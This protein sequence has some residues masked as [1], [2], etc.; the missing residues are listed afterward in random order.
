MLSFLDLSLAS[1]DFCFL[2]SVILL[3]NIFRAETFLDA[4]WFLLK[5]WCLS[6]GFSFC[7]PRF[8]L[9][10]TFSS[11][12]FPGLTRLSISVFA[13]PPTFFRCL[14]PNCY[15]F[16]DLSLASS[17]LRHFLMLSDFCC[18]W[19]FLLASSGL[20]HFL[21]V[22]AFCSEFDP[23]S[24]WLVLDVWFSFCIPRF[25][26]SRLSHLE[27]PRLPFT[28]ILSQKSQNVSHAVWTVRK[29]LIFWPPGIRFLCFAYS[30][31]TFIEIFLF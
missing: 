29:F 31:L 12:E 16:F 17:G 15:V 1:D 9:S 18:V 2:L 30:F 19:S 24:F 28:G 3:V 4:F 27:F 11:L 22:S 8:F 13:A 14:E 26:L 20:R 6:V 10:S 7:I 21:M 23:S 5:V 25:F